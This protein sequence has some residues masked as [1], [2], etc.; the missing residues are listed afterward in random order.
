VGRVSDEAPELLFRLLARPERGFDAREHG[1]QRE[2]EAA[3][4]G[5]LVRM[6]DSL[7]Q[8]AGRNRPCCL[9]HRGEGGAGSVEPP[10]ARAR[11]APPAQRR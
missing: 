3:D 7:R 10:R 11:P 4:L 1:V 2:P 8:I 5:A 9:L 6:L